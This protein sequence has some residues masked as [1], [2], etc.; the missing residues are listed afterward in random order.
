MTQE[1]QMHK[2][3]VKMYLLS[4]DNNISQKLNLID[5]LQRLSISYHFKSEIDE[6]LAQIYNDFAK[7]GLTIEAEECCD[8][9]LVSLLFRL[10]RQKGY[11]ISS[12]VFNK[13]KN[14]KGKFDEIIIVQDVQGMWSLYEAAQL[15][16]HGED[17]L[18]EAHEFTY[19]K[20]KSI[21]NQ[22]SQS[23]ADQINQSL[24]QPLY[25]AV[26]RMR[27]K[28]YMS[29]YKEAPS[30]DN[31]LLSFAK[32]DFNMLQKWY[33]KE[34]GINTKWW[35]ESDFARKAPYARDRVVE[36]FTWPYAMNS[37]PEYSTARL[38][39]TKVTACLSLL[40]DTYDIY[41]TVEELELFTE[42]IQRW[43]I[44]YIASLPE[45]FKVV[46]NAILEFWAEM[47][48]LTAENGESSYVL[49]HLKQIFCNLARAY[50]VEEKWCHEG[51][52]PTY[53][54]YKVNGVQTSAFPVMLSVFIASV[55]EFATK[56][57]LDWFSNIPPILEATSLICRIINDLASHK[58]EQQ[59]D[60]V[61]S[62]VECCM[63]QYGL[64]QEEAYEFINKDINYYW[65]NIN[66]EYL[67]L[68]KDM[69]EALLDLFVNLA[70][71]S[72]FM[73]ANFEDRYTNCQ[74]LK[75]HIMALLLDPIVV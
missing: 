16:V 11:Y 20:L 41:G 6:A 70:R 40:D 23:L 51:H 24:G 1:V 56:E 38:M 48:S 67:K 8:L 45:C 13:F 72:E 21:T 52:I 74:L 71:I 15:R 57:I 66:E 50:L 61:A 62:A 3:K 27:A 7:N 37:E 43:D 4:V 75:D 42:A 22:L 28:S 32:L 55:K 9:H 49:Q 63:K 58:F 26:P 12:D 53:D 36:V 54:D 47:D 19:N 39:T 18:E 25:K 65:K 2:K 44:S 33:R 29:F 46:F 60:H 69:P 68:I 10:L 64:S 5:S 73:Y 17:I 30:H 59:R 14:K 34:V 35:R 31:V